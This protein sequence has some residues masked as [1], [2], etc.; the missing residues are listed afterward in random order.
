V[1]SA[2]GNA[3]ANSYIGDSPGV[4]PG[5]AAS[6]PHNGHFVGRL[7][8]HHLERVMDGDLHA[9]PET[10]LG[11]TLRGGGR[12]YRQH[13]VEAEPAILHR[14]QCHIG[15]H[16]FGQRRRMPG[17]CRILRFQHLAAVGFDQQRR[18]GMGRGGCNRRQRKSRDEQHAAE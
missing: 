2:A 3:G 12:R 17:E 14:L 15:G 1:A 7:H 8:L 9:G 5:P 4:A 11:W 10:H 6:A 13:L 16:Q 18:F